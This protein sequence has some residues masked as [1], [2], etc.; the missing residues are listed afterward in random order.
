MDDPRVARERL[1]GRERKWLGDI[2]ASLDFEDTIWREQ[3]AATHVQ[4]AQAAFSLLT[5]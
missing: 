1:R 5:T 4:R 2:A 3:F